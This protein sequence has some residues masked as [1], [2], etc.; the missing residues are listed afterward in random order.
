ME[1][2]LHKLL[3]EAALR[4]LGKHGYTL[5]VE[6]LEPPFKR[7]FWDCYRPDVL[8]VISRE[9]DLIIVLVECETSPNMRRIMGKTLRIK[10]T[11]RLQKRLNER[12]TVH[13]LLIVPPNNLR[14]I[15]YSCIRRFWEIWI[16]HHQGEIMHKIPRKKYGNPKD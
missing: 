10:A 3:K 13:P 2:S 4:E 5:Y 12:H 14:K 7:L 9:D 6:P 15:N 1:G 8:G 16:T 11:L